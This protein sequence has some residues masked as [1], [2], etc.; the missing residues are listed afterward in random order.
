MT[1]CPMT[2]RWTAA[3]ML[4]SLAAAAGGCAKP[5][6]KLIGMS[7]THIDLKSATVTFDVDVTNPNLLDF[8]L[9]GLDYSLASRAAPLSISTSSGVFSI[10]QPGGSSIVSV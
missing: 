9:A 7:L 1:R 6:V 2:R 3:C 5:T 8:P 10:V 4:I